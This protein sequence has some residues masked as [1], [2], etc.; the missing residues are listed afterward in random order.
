MLVPAV[1]TILLLVALL[2][3]FRFAMGLRY[4][5]LLREQALLDEAARGRRVVAE[6]PT[7]G[8]QILLFRE[9]DARFY[10]AET[11]CAKRD[12]VA[13]RLLLNGAVVG[14]AA[15][16]GVAALPAAPG[17]DSEDLR[18]RWEVVA[19]RRGATPLTIPC[20][21]LRE[22]VSRDAAR[23]V[24]ESLRSAIDAGSAGRSQQEVGS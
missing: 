15:A 17:L 1:A 3:A 13:A 9:D 14:E 21:R 20:G 16:G 12:L 11:S 4:A 10:W 2:S 23:A 7:T 5:K 8:G 22:G 18:E 24:F 19:Y 6:V